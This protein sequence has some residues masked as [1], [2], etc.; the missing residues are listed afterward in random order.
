MAHQSI[1]STPPS[2]DQDEIAA[3]I[4][5]MLDSL[6]DLAQCAELEG[7]SPM[8]IATRKMVERTQ[9]EKERG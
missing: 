6:A 1:S 3:Y 7:F 4:T 9:Q 8:L 5:D 2:F